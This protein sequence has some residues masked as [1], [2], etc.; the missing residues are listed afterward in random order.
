MYVWYIPRGANLFIAVSTDV[1]PQNNAKELFRR[2]MVIQ[3]PHG[4]NEIIQP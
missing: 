2:Q 1:L 4:P 3:F